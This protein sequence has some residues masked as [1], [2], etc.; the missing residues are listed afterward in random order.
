VLEVPNS[1]LPEH[2]GIWANTTVGGV[3]I[4]RMGRPAINTVFNAGTDK[5]DFNVTVPSNDT[6]AFDGKFVTNVK[7]VL[8]AFSSLDTEG[9]YSDGVQSA[10]AGVLLPDVLPYDVGTPTVGAFNGRALVDDVIDTELN[11]VTGGF[12]VDGVRDGVG[13]V[14]T[15]CVGPHSNYMDSF[16]YLGDPH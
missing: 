6:T 16:P 10:L 3:Q 15:D 5:N 7:G 1:W 11:I 8:A 9:A 2:V 4:D 13:A 14:P 12:A